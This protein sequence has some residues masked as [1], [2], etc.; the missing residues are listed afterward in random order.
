MVCI[1]AL[2]YIVTV[3]VASIIYLEDELNGP[4]ELVFFCSVIERTS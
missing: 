2:L 3:A 4:E 1:V